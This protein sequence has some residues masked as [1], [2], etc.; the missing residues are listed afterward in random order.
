MYKEKNIF[1]KS[2]VYCLGRFFSLEVSF[3]QTDI[4]KCPER[5]LQLPAAVN[6]R[7]AGWH[8]QRKKSQVSI[9]TG[10]PSTKSLATPGNT[11]FCSNH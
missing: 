1:S 10:L 4:F 11:P 3:C 2:S 8:S 6:T 9:V 7:T 5:L